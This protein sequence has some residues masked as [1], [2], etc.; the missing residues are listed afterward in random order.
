MNR[1]FHFAPRLNRDKVLAALQ[2]DGDVAGFAFYLAAV[3]VPEPTELRQE[4]AVVPL[5]QRELLWVGV[6]EALSWPFFLNRGGWT[7]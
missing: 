3:A 7:T 6:A 5:L 2:R 1:G 4:D